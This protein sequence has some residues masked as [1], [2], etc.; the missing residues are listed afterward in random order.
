MRTATEASHLIIPP[1]LNGER[2]A[3]YDALSTVP[4]YRRY[5]TS[6][7][8]ARGFEELY[9]QHKDGDGGVRV[10]FDEIQVGE[11]ADAVTRKLWSI[12]P[13][14]LSREEAEALPNAFVPGN[15]HTNEVVW[16][17]TYDFLPKALCE[18]PELLRILGHRLLFWDIY[19]AG[20]VVNGDELFEENEI[21]LGFLM[22]N[23]GRAQT[24]PEWDLSVRYKLLSH[25]SSLPDAKALEYI[26]D[27]YRPN[28][29]QALHNGLLNSYVYT[30]RRYPSFYRD[31]M[32]LRSAVRPVYPPNTDTGDLNYPKMLA[33]GVYY[34]FDA[35]V[36]Y[37]DL[38]RTMGSEQVAARHVWGNNI[39]GYLRQSIKGSMAVTDESG[40]LISDALAP[41]GCRLAQG[42]FT[43]SLRDA[44]VGHVNGALQ[45]VLGSMGA[46][47]DKVS[48]I[49]D[50]QLTFAQRLQRGT[51]QSL[52]IYW[53]AAGPAIQ[54]L[55]LSNEPLAN[56]CWPNLFKNTVLYPAI[57]LGAARRLAASRGLDELAAKA[58][59]TIN[60]VN[61][62]S[63]ELIRPQAVPRQTQVAMQAGSI[64]LGVLASRPPLR[65]PATSVYMLKYLRAGNLG[66][67]KSHPA[68]IGG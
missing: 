33:P 14:P 9:E 26:I 11:G 15:A 36:L 7:E 56:N 48:G 47:L 63:Q 8:V 57:G 37:D 6:P 35:L 31:M 67:C 34:G 38:T 42:P 12:E 41:N 43:R 44:M 54:K 51:I 23:L 10:G 55:Q 5:H 60:M 53:S 40:Y 65:P 64:L 13:S 61:R 46:V 45:S 25:I 49:P 28:Y 68:L 4:D 32:Q 39:Q 62:A 16:T 18:H 27:R 66:P 2:R 52:Y 19:P 58:G 24:L 3:V 22:N 29:G 20:M 50:A 30:L 17:L 1:G 21:S 59:T